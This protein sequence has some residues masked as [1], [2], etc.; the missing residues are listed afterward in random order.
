M[1]S[2]FFEDFSGCVDG[3]PVTSDNTVFDPVVGSGL[4]VVNPNST[5][6]S[7]LTGW[8]AR[9][10]ETTV[11]QTSDQ[12]HSGT[13][14]MQVTSTLGD[15]AFALSTAFPIQVF[16]TWWTEA[17]VYA[18]SGVTRIVVRMYLYDSEG[19]FLEQ[20]GVQWTAPTPGEWRR[21]RVEIA[22]DEANETAA[23]CRLE[24]EFEGSEPLGYVDDIVF[25]YSHEST[26][27]TIAQQARPGLVG[28][29]AR[30]TQ[31]DAG[32]APWKD[33]GL[34]TDPVT[35]A[36]TLFFRS[37]VSVSSVTGGNLTFMWLTAPESTTPIVSIGVDA[38]ENL[39]GAGLSLASGSA[40]LGTFLRWSRVDVTVT[41]SGDDLLVNA[42]IFSGINLNS[43]N[44]ALR[45]GQLTG[46]IVGGAALIA[47]GAWL[48]LGRE[49][50]TTPTGASLIVD[51]VSFDAVPQP[52][53][54]HRMDPNPGFFVVRSGTM[55]RAE[56]L[57]TW[58]GSAIDDAEF[59]GS[60]GGETIDNPV[61]DIDTLWLERWPTNGAVGSPWSV[62]GQALSTSGGRTVALA[63]AQR[64][65]AVRSG[66]AGDGHLGGLAARVSQTSTNGGVLLDLR[67]KD[68]STP[69]DEG[70]DS[71]I[72]IGVS[73]SSVLA[74]AVFTLSIEA[75]G[76]SYAIATNIDYTQ[77]YD[78]AVRL[79]GNEARGYI[80]RVLIG[81]YVLSTADLADLGSSARLIIE[82]PATV[83][84]LRAENL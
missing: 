54:R 14:S 10:P 69:T 57:G 59:L 22:V 25:R 47:S 9:F 61:P 50:S 81:S 40:T 7:G 77:F 68:P 55:P 15:D 78:L 46:T 11:T 83:G 21:L 17:W 51:Q 30:L 6:E 33:A 62:N 56:L 63:A 2:P 65:R 5:F 42:D 37:Y 70:N 19:V 66:P 24:V 67:L 80:N 8:A 76:T 53:P 60:W 72:R 16:E 44:T 38:S 13:Y 43:D 4:S 36:R 52:P 74:T 41:E 12:A 39:V 27:A 49:T 35:E 79:V 45:V 64:G 75:T 18:V 20:R 28:L 23:N 26:L 29:G 31:A 34:F 48:W 1:P 71:Y 73:G 3:Q 84:P 32:G 58:D 82:G